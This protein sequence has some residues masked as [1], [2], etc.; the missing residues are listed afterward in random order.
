MK[1]IPAGS[2]L[3]HWFLAA[4]WI[5][6]ATSR[7]ASAAT[8]PVPGARLWMETSNAGSVLTNGTSVTNWVDQSGNGFDVFQGTAENQPT[9]SAPVAAIKNQRVLDFDGNDYLAN[10]LDGVFTGGYATVFIVC[11]DDH[12]ESEY[13][14]DMRAN[15]A[16]SRR[17]F[18]TEAAAI[19]YYAMRDGGG[20]NLQFADPDTNAFEYYTVVFNGNASKAYVNGREDDT[21][22]ISTDASGSLVEF[23]IGA[24]M[25]TYS[26]GFDGRLAEI[27]IYT[28]A[29]SD[30]ERHKIEFYLSRK[31]FATPTQTLPVS[32]AQAWFETTNPDALVL[33]G[34]AVEVWVDQTGH[35]FDVSQDTAAERPALTGPVAEVH[36]HRVL[37]FDGNDY[38]TVA[39]DGVFAGGYA[40]VF[41]V[42]DDDHDE[43][44][45]IIDTGANGA[46]SRRMFRTG[47]AAMY[48]VQRDA[49]A[50][51]TYLGFADP[52]TNAFEY[53]TMVFNGG[54]SKAYVN[55][56]EDDTAAISTDASGSLAEFVIGAR[57]STHGGGFDGRLA[58][59]VI[60][61]NALGNTDRE[62]VELYLKEKYFPDVGTLV[63]VR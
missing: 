7:I 42:C 14:I 57:L 38:L 28:N 19:G 13:I 47:T 6:L 15:G 48:Y 33:T 17:M 9:L 27:I 34:T 61:T 40:T 35:G 53:Y 24:R 16:L 21:A 23:V 45:Y 58:E 63:I 36:D 60:Y 52:D 44:E 18:R 50:G 55:G 51:G 37:D 32:G 54:A 4:G 59:I 62:A 29:L 3:L 5:V 25:T 10:A 56:K 1:T 12:D 2:G 20:G 8:L 39:A 22:T 11:D 49:D 26:G 46:L 30:V 43:Y 31:Y 41:F